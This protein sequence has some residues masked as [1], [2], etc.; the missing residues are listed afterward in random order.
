MHFADFRTIM[1][2]TENVVCFHLKEPP[3]TPTT[4]AYRLRGNV[5]RPACAP[6]RMASSK[7]DLATASPERKKMTTC[8]MS[9]VECGGSLAP[10]QPIIA[11]LYTLVGVE[12]VDHVPMR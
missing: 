8:H 7:G 10:D 1:D 11:R 4:P 3:A 12:V 9:C 5:P 6:R 2:E